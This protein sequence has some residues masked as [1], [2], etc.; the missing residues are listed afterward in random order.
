MIKVYQELQDKGYGYAGWA[1]GVATAETVT[2]IA[3]VDY[4]TGTALI[5]LG[6]QECRNLGQVQVDAIRVGMA[7]GYVRALLTKANQANNNGFVSSDVDQS[8]F[9][10]FRIGEIQLYIL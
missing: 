5:G 1:K 7:D 6:G 9:L 3:A 10:G 4:L 2:G 8:G